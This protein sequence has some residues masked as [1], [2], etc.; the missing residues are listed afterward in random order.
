MSYLIR[1]ISIVVGSSIVLYGTASWGLSATE[2]AKI[3]KAATVKIE[4]DNSQGSG[5][6]IQQQ[7]GQYVVLTAAHVV[8]NSGSPSRRVISNAYLNDW[9]SAEII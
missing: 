6:I 7:A 4:G 5:Q 1:L 8:R 3:A 2:V 9:S